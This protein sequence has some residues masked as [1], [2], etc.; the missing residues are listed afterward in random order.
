MAVLLVQAAS[1]ERDEL[2]AA[3]RARGIEVVE[4]ADAESAL[5]AADGGNVDAVLT[6]V[7][8]LDGEEFGLDGR[9]EVRCGRPVPVL[10]LAHLAD[11]ARRAVLERHGAALLGRPATDVEALAAQIAAAVQSMA[12]AAKPAS[13]SP[14]ALGRMKVERL[15]VTDEEPIEAPVGADGEAP[16]VLIVDDDP[17]ARELFAKILSRIGYRTHL[18]SSAGGAIRFL[19]KSE[20]VALIVS[21]LQMPQM[22]GLEFKDSMER[23]AIPFI[24]VTAHDT[25]EQR[26]LAKKLGV[27]AYLSKPIQARAFAKA[28][29]EAVLSRRGS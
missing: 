6:E 24:L 18:V 26:N 1:R 21:D 7:A 14:P 15:A 2:A 8:V 12:A 17:D 19:G 10:A 29:R 3:L 4:T 16:L 5:E 13:E 23:S 28:V 25:V 11:P 27:A 20:G 22:D 9:L